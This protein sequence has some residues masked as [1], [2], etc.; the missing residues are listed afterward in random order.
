MHWELLH[1]QLPFR[2][3]LMKSTMLSPVLSVIA[4]SS[5]IGLV[6][7]SNNGQAITPQMGWDN[8]NAFGCDVSENLLQTQAKLIVDLGLK[9]LGYKYIVLDDCWSN[10]RNTSGNGS[11]IVNTEKFPRGMA[12]VANDIHDLGLK[13]GMYSDAGRY[14]CGQY[15]GSLDHEEVDAKTFASWGV[16]YL[17]V[18]D[19]QESEIEVFS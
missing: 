8:W 2:P 14:T 4:A 11:I 10:G 3:R 18:H 7:S 17:K 16:D 1:L 13:F 6:Q 12:A 5:F 15:E 19:T 9:D